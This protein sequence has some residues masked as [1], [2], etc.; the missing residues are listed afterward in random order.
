[1]LSLPVVI[2]LPPKRLGFLA[3]SAAVAPLSTGFATVFRLP[4][5]EPPVAGLIDPKSPVVAAAGFGS[6]ALTGSGRALPPKVPPEVALK[7]GSLPLYCALAP[8]KSG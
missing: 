6:S 3:G 4:K 1:M 2:G 8:P 7:S 5:R